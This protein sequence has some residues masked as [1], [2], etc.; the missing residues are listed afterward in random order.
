MLEAIGFLTVLAIGFYI[1]IAY[2][3]KP[4]K[5]QRELSEIQAKKKID[6]K[7]KEESKILFISK[8]K[9]L[10]LPLFKNMKLKQSE[11]EEKIANAYNYSN[12]EV[13]GIC[14]YP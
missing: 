9:D 3:S 5:A 4:S 11:L 1:L 8:Y 14:R 7:T 12:N 6:E 2:I 10:V 13:D